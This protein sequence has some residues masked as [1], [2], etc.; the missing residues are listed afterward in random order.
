MFYILFFFCTKSWK[1]SVYFTLHHFS[2]GLA[3]SMLHGHVGLVAIGLDSAAL[4]PGVFSYAE[5]KSNTLP[6]FIYLFI[7]ILFIYLFYFCLRWVFVAVRGLLITVASLFAG[8][9]L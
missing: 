5:F 9:G 3:T 7:T 4:N 6:F 2:V 1:S 8:H